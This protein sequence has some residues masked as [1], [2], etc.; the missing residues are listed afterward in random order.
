[1]SAQAHV[2]TV[3]LSDRSVDLD[4]QVLDLR[5][6]EYRLLAFLAVHPGRVYTRY[7]LS[8]ALWRRVE[9]HSN[10]AVDAYVARIRKHLGALNGCIRTIN[11]VGYSLDDNHIVVRVASPPTAIPLATTIPTSIAG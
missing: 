1:V 11:R 2:L 7:A 6:Q 10:R 8:Q 5:R 4:G 9:P 3:N